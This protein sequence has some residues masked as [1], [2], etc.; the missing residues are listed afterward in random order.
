MN[1]NWKRWIALGLTISCL[2]SATVMA[3]GVQTK[4]YIVHADSYQLPYKG[5]EKAFNHPGPGFRTNEQS[6]RVLR[7]YNN[8]QSPDRDKQSKILM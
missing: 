5:N 6:R 3:E 7:Q 2:G 1:K 4:S 8:L